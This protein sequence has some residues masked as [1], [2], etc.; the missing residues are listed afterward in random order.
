MS[1]VEAPL[2]DLRDALSEVD[3]LAVLT[4]EAFDEADRMEPDSAVVDDMA[5]L[6]RLI[7]KSSFAAMSAYHRLR[8]SMET[9][10]R[11]PLGLIF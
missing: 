4:G 6:L 7:E 5:T 2:D 3:V 1:D 10:R 8:W 11:K 9:P